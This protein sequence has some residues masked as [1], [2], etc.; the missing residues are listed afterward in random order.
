LVSGIYVW[1]FTGN[2][3]KDKAIFLVEEVRKIIGLN[4]SKVD[5]IA[6]I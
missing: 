6:P 3:D 5:D 2:Y 1:F 4:A